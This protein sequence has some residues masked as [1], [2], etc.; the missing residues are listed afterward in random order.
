MANEA[1]SDESIA[2]RKTGRSIFTAS[3]DLEK[4]LTE[5]ETIEV[6]FVVSSAGDTRVNGEWRC[7]EPGKFARIADKQARVQW[8]EGSK[9]WQLLYGEELLYRLPSTGSTSILEGSWL[10]MQ[11]KEP[12][13]SLAA[14][15]SRQQ[16][17]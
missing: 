1:R 17:R 7:L 12:T 3:A 6:A 15:G 2:F 13:P 14:V 5:F 10:A 16:D 8:D 9:H 11:G 4:D